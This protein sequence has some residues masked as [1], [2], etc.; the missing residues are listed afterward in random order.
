MARKRVATHKADQRRRA[1]YFV[2]A[3]GSNFGP[4]ADAG[5]TICIS[6]LGTRCTY[7][8]SAG[9]HCISQGRRAEHPPTRSWS[10]AEKNSVPPVCSHCQ[11][12]KWPSL[13]GH[14]IRE[15]QQQARFQKQGDCTPSMSL[16]HHHPNHRYH[17]HVHATRRSSPAT[18]RMPLRSV[19]ELRFW[20]TDRIA[21]PPA[22]HR[23][24]RCQL[25]AR[26]RRSHTAPA[27]ER[28]SAADPYCEQGARKKALEPGMRLKRWH[29]NIATA[30]AARKF[31]TAVQN[32]APPGP[33][34]RV[35]S[36]Q[37]PAE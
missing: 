19:P 7:W 8:P 18:A 12:P 15:G 27:L 2:A 20:H 36:P 16:H 14:R 13:Q 22:S 28:P 37:Y 17:Q 25:P 26:P 29:P 1:E 3:Y 24:I 9:R 4:S 5:N 32:F 10:A 6:T 23:R 35:W 34:T 33:Q 21:P 30:S 31:A 11:N